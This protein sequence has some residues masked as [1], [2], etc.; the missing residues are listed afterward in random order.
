VRLP[1]DEHGGLDA[2]RAD[3]TVSGLDHSGG[4]YELRV[5]LNNPSADAG[6]PP[7]AGAGYAGSIHVYGYGAPPPPPATGGEGA[8]ATPIR[9]TR[10]IIATDAIRSQPAAGGR[11][12]VTLVA[13][14]VGGTEADVDLDE[15]GVS[16]RIDA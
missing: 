2:G 12:S 6:T 5:F 8:S 10:S 3:I 1:P 15:A 14:G 4:S 13:V 7:T 16:V 9:K 11:V